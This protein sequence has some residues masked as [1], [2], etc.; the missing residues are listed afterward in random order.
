[1]VRVVIAG[2]VAGL[3]L[4]LWGFVS[5]VVLTWH[6][7]TFVELPDEVGLVAA[8]RIYLPKDSN[9][10]VQS[11]TYRVPWVK[12][13]DLANPETRAKTEEDFR[14]RHMEGPVAYLFYSEAGSDPMAPQR[15][16]AGAGLYMLAAFFAALAVYIS[17]PGRPNFLLRV[18]IVLAMGCFTVL[19]T[20]LNDWNFMYR[21]DDYTL[22]MCADN[23]VSAL[24]AGIVIAIIVRP[25]PKATTT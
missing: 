5:W 23:L 21:P 10:E 11:G 9:Q 25:G 15:L 2:V 18:G 19:M 12:S 8:L 1:M 14:R 4:F 16:A 13:S 6:A 17:L 24:L 3:V 22:A 20:H 7:E